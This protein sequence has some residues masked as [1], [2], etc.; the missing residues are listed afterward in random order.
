MVKS[1]KLSIINSISIKNTN[2]FNLI[3]IL[4]IAFNTSSKT[5]LNEGFESP[6]F[7]FS[8]AN[9]S[10]AGTISDLRAAN[11]KYHWMTAQS[12]KN[13]FFLS[14]DNNYQ[15]TGG[16]RY[17]LSFKMA[18]EGC[19]KPHQLGVYLTEARGNVQLNSLAVVD[20]VKDVLPEYRQL[21][22]EFTPENNTTAFLTFRYDN[23][24]YFCASSTIL[25]DDIV[26]MEDVAVLPP[27]P[28]ITFPL[29]NANYQE[30]DALIGIKINGQELRPLNAPMVDGYQLDFESDLKFRAGGSYGIDLM[31]GSGKGSH[32]LMCYI[33][34]NHDGDWLDPYENQA[35]LQNVRENEPKT[36]NLNL[37]K[38]TQTGHY[39]LRI[40]YIYN[41]SEADPLLG[42]AWGN[43]NDILFTVL[44][45]AMQSDAK[46]EDCTYFD[47][48][49]RKISNPNYVASGIYI[50]K[51]GNYSEKIWISNA[52]R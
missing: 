8:L 39:I 9:S 49:G 23:S 43:T 7:L 37:P 36:F 21:V 2:F 5:I 50:R 19:Y 46:S 44:N 4:L 16:T 48:S 30:T 26:L 25:L 28:E 24:D 45:D 11:G 29:V 3:L 34:L 15:F 17:L 47:L 27:R 12:G 38:E 52:L 51:C 35:L 40:R 22:F 20:Q 13:T 18:A 42:A 1:Y 41:V 31:S 32:A 10:S 14:S 6:S 33:D